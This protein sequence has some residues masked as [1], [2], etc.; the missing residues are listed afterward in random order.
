MSHHLCV[1]DNDTVY[2]YID[3]DS[4]RVLEINVT[5]QSFWQRGQ[6]DATYTNPWVNQPNIAPFNQEFYLIF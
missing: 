3:N 4:N 5:S 1:R 2:T 6:F